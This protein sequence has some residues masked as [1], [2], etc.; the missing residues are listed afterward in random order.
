MNETSQDRFVFLNL[1]SHRCSHPN[2]GASLLCCHPDG[3][4]RACRTRC[5]QSNIHAATLF[6]ANFQKWLRPDTPSKMDRYICFLVST[7][8]AI[9][10][11]A[12]GISW[13]GTGRKSSCPQKRCL[14]AT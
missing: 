7:G 14:R 2:F 3:P 8:V 1:T 9:E 6:F 11:M 13:K 12:L 5:G 4:V 10:G